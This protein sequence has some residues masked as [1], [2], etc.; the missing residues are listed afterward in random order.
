MAELTEGKGF[1]VGEPCFAKV[2]GYPMWPAEVTAV[3]GSRYEVFFFGTHEVAKVG[4]KDIL[5]ATPANVEKHSQSP[6]INRKFY[7]EGLQEMKEF[8][9]KASGTVKRVS[10]PVDETA[11]SSPSLSPSKSPSKKLKLETPFQ[12]PLITTKEFAKTVVEKSPKRKSALKTPDK[13]KEKSPKSTA[14]KRSA[15][16]EVSIS[17]K[18]TVNKPA[19]YQEVEDEANSAAAA[20]ISAA[21]VSRK[22]PN[23]RRMQ[24]TNNDDSGDSKEAPN[25]DKVKLSINLNL[26]MSAEVFVRVAKELPQLFALAGADIGKK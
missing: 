7:K 16:S 26:E 1:E 12:V 13:T 18:R 11:Q 5:K 10:F 21:G 3:A 17:P 22:S 6:F 9:E 24:A 14:V 19:R 8:S 15:S 4:P 20:V 23:K 25:D 2:K